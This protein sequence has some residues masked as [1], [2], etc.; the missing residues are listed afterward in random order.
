MKRELFT[1]FWQEMSDFQN[2]STGILSKCEIQSLYF[3]DVGFLY[4]MMIE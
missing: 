3:K 1:I 2:V 4:E